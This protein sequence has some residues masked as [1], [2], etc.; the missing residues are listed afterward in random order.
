LFA[1]PVPSEHYQQPLLE[2][3][4]H[5]ILD[6]VAI[7]FREQGFKREKETPNLVLYT[8]PDG[9]ARENTKQNKKENE[10]R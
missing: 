9:G 8:N 5:P 4:I 1:V 3:S 10:Q 7:S 2:A 6:A